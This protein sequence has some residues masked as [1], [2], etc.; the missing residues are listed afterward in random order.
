L[1]EYTKREGERLVIAREPGDECMPRINFDGDRTV[2][3][4]EREKEKY[5]RRTGKN[6]S[7]YFG[8]EA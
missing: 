6:D 7:G 2:G 4:G 5:G 3:G 1:R 8:T